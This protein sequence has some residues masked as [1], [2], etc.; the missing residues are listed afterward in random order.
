MSVQHFLPWRRVRA[1][2]DWARL[3]RLPY[4]VHPCTGSP[5]AHT[6]RI[7]LLALFFFLF[8]ELK[9]S[10]LDMPYDFYFY[11]ITFWVY[12]LPHREIRS[13]FLNQRGRALHESIGSGIRTTYLSVSSFL[14][15]VRPWKDF[16]NDFWRTCYT[17]PFSLT[18][19]A[20]PITFFKK[21]D[22]IA[23][24]LAASCWHLKLHGRWH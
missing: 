22:V 10:S 23:F 18:L 20:C 13:K 9:K 1:R 16:L 11:S 4:R 24:L 8:M 21:A 14:E 2:E 7:S 6:N 17:N 19:F 5:L 3:P 15:P 12:L